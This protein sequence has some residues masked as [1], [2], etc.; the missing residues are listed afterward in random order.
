MDLFDWQTKDV[1]L[2]VRRIR[3]DLAAHPEVLTTAEKIE[4]AHIDAAKTLLL[5]KAIVGA[6]ASTVIPGKTIWIFQDFQMIDMPWQ[7]YGLHELLKVGYFIGGAPYATLFFKFNDK[8]PSKTIARLT[9]DDFTIDEK[10][11]AVDAVYDI[12]ERNFSHLFVGRLL[13]SDFRAGTK[14]YCYKM[15]GDSDR[16]R[17]EFS[18]VS[19]T[20]RSHPGSAAHVARFT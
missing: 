2:A 8:M 16:A 5:W 10:I 9:A 14:A 1:S 11:S 7:I 3:A 18:A 12:V 4:I 17:V 19:P 6:L 15:M 13:V 20:F